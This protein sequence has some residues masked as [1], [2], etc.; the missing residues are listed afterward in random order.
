MQGDI[1]RKAL[2]FRGKKDHLGASERISTMQNFRSV[3]LAAAGIVV[4]AIAA[5]RLCQGKD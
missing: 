2:A 4:L 1:W 5:A 3:A